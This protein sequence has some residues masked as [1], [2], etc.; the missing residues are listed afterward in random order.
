MTVQTRAAAKGTATAATLVRAPFA[1]VS[2]RPATPSKL[3][4]MLRGHLGS[5]V[6][7]LVAQDH[8][9]E[10][11]TTLGTG[12]VLSRLSDAIAE[13]SH[14]PGAQLHRSHWVARAHVRALV[15]GGGRPLVRL[16]DGRELPV[17]EARLP[18]VRRALGL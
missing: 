6:I 17:S 5:D 10:V 14:R 9:V 8:Y 11:T 3:Q 2:P 18:K 7:S 16:S 13:L 1:P 4:E 12:L 15:R